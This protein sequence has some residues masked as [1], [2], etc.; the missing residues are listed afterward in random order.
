V[1][2]FLYPIGCVLGLSD[3]LNSLLP[4]LTPL[5]Y[6]PPAFDLPLSER[7]ALNLF[8]VH[9]SHTPL[10]AQPRLFL[11]CR[12]LVLLT[13]FLLEGDSFRSL[14]TIL[15][16]PPQYNAMF[17]RSF[18]FPTNFSDSS[19]NM[20]KTSKMDPFLVA[21]P[22]ASRSPHSILQLCSV[23]RAPSSPSR[24]PSKFVNWVTV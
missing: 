10:L 2:F 8:E 15:H 12:V 13:Q 1:R 11:E 24:S 22:Q 3:M 17:S 18:F 5:T 21:P 20:S 23:L 7:I 6:S 19:L 4:W 14:R 16:Q 9:P